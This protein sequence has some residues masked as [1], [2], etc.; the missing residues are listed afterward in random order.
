MTHLTT[1]EV[2][3]P[4]CERPEMLGRAVKSVQAQTYPHWRA[5]VFDDSSSS[6]SRDVIQRIADDRISYV[7]NPQRLGAAG[8]IDQCFSPVKILGG[9]YG[10]LLEDDN[11]WLPDFLS[12]IVDHMGKSGC[13]LIQANQRISEEGVGLHDVSE[14]TRGG[15][16]SGGSVEPLN[17][18][19]TMFFMEGI[20]TGGLIWRLGGGT[21]LRVG[22]KVEHFTLQEA[23]RSLLVRT[24]FLFIEEAQAV[25]TLMPISQSARAIDRY[26]TVGRG[27]QSIR[28]YLLKT[29]GESIVH[30]ARSVATKMGLTDRLVEALAY[31]G[32]PFM[33]GDFLKGRYLLACRA[34]TKGLAIRMVETDPSS[35]FLQSLPNWGI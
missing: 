12:L 20:S 31:S 28:D 9:D 5:V 22:E 19:A 13:E 14:T 24:P 23:S 32:Y 26:R 10:C 34:A 4:A 18:R 2:R 7:R 6:N 8:N 25:W 30:A 33:A 11:F 21:D 17:L 27:M 29:H 15:W 1:F 35:A 16:F 3:I